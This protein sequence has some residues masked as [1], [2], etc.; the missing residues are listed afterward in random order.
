[1]DKNK[2]FSNQQVKFIISLLLGSIVLAFLMLALI[3]KMSLLPGEV[4]SPFN[5]KVPK[6]TPKVFLEMKV[7]SDKI[8]KSKVLPVSLYLDSQGKKIDGVGID[9]LY[10]PRFLDIDASKVVA[11]NSELP[12]VIFPVRKMPKGE[13]KFSLISSVNGYF[14]GKGKIA[15]LKF[16]VLREGTTDL[17]FKFK[18]GATD[19]C[20]V[21]LYKKGV[22]VLDEVRGGGQ[23]FL[24]FA[25]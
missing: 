5:L 7:S 2:Y 9:I 13:L 17:N 20:N 10:D 11:E 22:D 18:P 16:K 24:T 6:K 1:M 25:K 23:V 12:K 14:Q 19:D 3:E 4:S 21:V 15:T 8:S